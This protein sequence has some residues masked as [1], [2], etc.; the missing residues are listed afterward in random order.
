MKKSPSDRREDFNDVYDFESAFDPQFELSGN[1]D[2][3]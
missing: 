3:T 2:A 1:D